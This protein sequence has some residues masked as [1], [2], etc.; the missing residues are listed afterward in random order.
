MSTASSLLTRCPLYS[1]KA[2]QSLPWH[3]GGLTPQLSKLYTAQAVHDLLAWI[4]QFPRAAIDRTAPPDRFS[5]K[6]AV[7][8][9]A[10][11]VGAASTLIPSFI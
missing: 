3:D 1:L 10:V 9:P 11:S 5:A 4:L 7:P 2:H 6:D 8:S